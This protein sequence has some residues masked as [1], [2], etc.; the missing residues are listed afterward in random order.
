MRFFL[1]RQIGYEEIAKM[2]IHAGA[3]V[4]IKNIKGMTALMESAYHGISIN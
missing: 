2:L 1:I 3:Q 4:D